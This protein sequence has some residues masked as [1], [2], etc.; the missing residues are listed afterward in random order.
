MY[1]IQDPSTCYD[2]IGSFSSDWDEDPYHNWTG[3]VYTYEKRS[4]NGNVFEN[5]QEQYIIYQAT[6]DVIPRDAVMGRWED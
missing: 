4:L 1:Y 2:C 6:P 5:E 3:S